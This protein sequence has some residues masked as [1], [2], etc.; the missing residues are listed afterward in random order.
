MPFK[1]MITAIIL[2]LVLPVVMKST[3]DLARQQQEREL[4]AE[5]RYLADCIALLYRQGLNA[6]KIVELDLPVSTG[7]LSAG[8]PLDNSRMKDLITIQFRTFHGELGRTAV[9]SGYSY[10]SMS[11]DKNTEFKINQGGT[12]TVLLKKCETEID[13]NSDERVP[14]FYIQLSLTKAAL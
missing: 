10:I 7:L 3:E 14:D 1:L 12:H 13:L 11:S 9:K 8:G 6:T 4:E 5:C 2:V